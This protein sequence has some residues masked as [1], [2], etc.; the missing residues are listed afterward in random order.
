[1]NNDT[2]NLI[3]AMVLSMAVLFG[4]GFISE[5]FFP[6]SREPATEFVDGEQ[7]V[8]P[9]G[10]AGPVS[11]TPTA[12]RDRAEVLTDSPRVLIDTPALE[13]SINLTV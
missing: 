3:L 13:G 4:W 12:I 11:I 5:E 6:T 2:R 1:M 10:D 9:D 7:V 8:L